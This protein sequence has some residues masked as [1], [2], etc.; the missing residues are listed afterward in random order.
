[1]LRHFRLLA[2]GPLLLLGACGM[3]GGGQQTAGLTVD[4]PMEQVSEAAEEA[5]DE[6][7]G[8]AT[9]LGVRTLPTGPV[10]VYQCQPG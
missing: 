2:L 6:L 10:A 8:E 7:N 9:L 5:C 4:D 3:M 1:M